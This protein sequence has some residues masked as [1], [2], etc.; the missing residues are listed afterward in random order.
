V[1]P[2]AYECSTPLTTTT[3]ANNQYPS[4]TMTNNSN[5]SL[6]MIHSQQYRTSNETSL[7]H[8][9]MA[10]NQYPS[11]TMTNNSN[12]SLHMIHSQQYRTSNE[13]SLS[14][15]DSTNIYEEIRPPFDRHSCC[16]CCSCTL[17]H[18]QKQHCISS[19]HQLTPHYYTCEPQQPSSNIVCQTC[20]IESF[21]RKQNST[22]TMNCVC[23][24]F[25]VPIK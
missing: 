12:L 9:D 8:L 24:N 16:C 5:L 3:M 11:L 19:N 14:H 17:A 20:L 10:N 21:H 1:L 2:I 4:L 25:F 22:L 6:H 13:T 18:Y 15:L 7:S 23:R